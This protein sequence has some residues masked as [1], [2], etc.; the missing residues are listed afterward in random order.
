MNAKIAEQLIQCHCGP[1]EGC[2]EPKIRKALRYAAKNNEL[3]GKLEGQLKLDAGNLD[4]IGSIR[5]PADLE[6]QFRA[7]KEP[8]AQAFSF[9]RALRQPPVLV[10]IIALLVLLGWFVYSAVIRA[11]DFP[12]REAVEE[13]LNSTA[14]MTGTELDPKETEAGLLG[15]WFYSQY[16]FEDYYVPA[17]IARLKTAGCRVFKQDGFPVAQIAINEHQSFLFVFNS[18]DFGVKIKQGD[19]WRVYELDDWVV[20]LLSHRDVCV[21]LAFHGTKNEMRHFLAEP[22]NK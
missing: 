4:W 1:G 16:G 20:G 17:D 14:E 2:D 6:E 22:A 8:S 5:L 3:R 18:D 21:M 19:R 11:D 10:V 13:M 9:K 7:I 15:D 12:G